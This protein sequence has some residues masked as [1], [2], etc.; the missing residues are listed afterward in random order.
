M[1]ESKFVFQANFRLQAGILISH[2]SL[3]TSSHRRQVIILYQAKLVKNIGFIILASQPIKNMLID[4]IF[5][6]VE[7]L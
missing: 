6:T 2:K 3:T 7:M 1:H 4:Y 5:W